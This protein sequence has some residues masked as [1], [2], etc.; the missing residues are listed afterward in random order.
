MRLNVKK[1]STECEIS[2]EKRSG[3]YWAS[4]RPVRDQ[5]LGK[6][7]YWMKRTFWIWEYRPEKAPNLAL[8]RPYACEQRDQYLPDMVKGG[9]SVRTWL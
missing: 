9:R 8:A 5:S 3:R 1:K 4:Q 2:P 7:S 6:M